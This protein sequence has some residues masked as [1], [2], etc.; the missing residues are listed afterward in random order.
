MCVITYTN[1]YGLEVARKPCVLGCLDS[2]KWSD[3]LDY[4]FALIINY[5]GIILYMN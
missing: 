3:G 5:A 1:F 4:K 2:V